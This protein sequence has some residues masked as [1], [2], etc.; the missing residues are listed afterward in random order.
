VKRGAFLAGAF[1]G[2]CAAVAALV[3]PVAWTAL[4]ACRTAE[5]YVQTDLYVGTCRD[6]L[7]GWLSV[8]APVASLALA[9]YRNAR[10]GARLGLRFFWWFALLAP[11]AAAFA[12]FFVRDGS[13]LGLSGW[14]PALDWR[15]AVPALG[16]LMQLFVF[17]AASVS[18]AAVL[19][20]AA[21][22]VFS[23]L[24]P[25]FGFFAAGL[26][27]SGALP[28]RAVGAL[29]PDTQAFWFADFLAGGGR[30]PAGDAI[31][32]AAY[33]AA[34]CGAALIPGCILFGKRDL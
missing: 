31:L 28:L 27:A 12:G 2:S 21:A 14:D 10:S 30:V 34:W 1:A 19:P 15:L 29:L 7:C 24:M 20:P 13:W 5:S 23:L 33:C 3:W 26:C 6:A 16:V 22:A 17:A 25:A 8:C 9:A 11:A 32:S 4:L 18:L